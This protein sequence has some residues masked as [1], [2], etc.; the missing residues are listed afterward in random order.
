MYRPPSFENRRRRFLALPTA[1]LAALLLDACGGGKAPSIKIEAPEPPPQTRLVMEVSASPKLNLN[2]DGTAAPLVVRIY[3]L[4]G[5]GQFLGS[6]FFPLFEN[7]SSTLGPDLIAREEIRVVPGETR[8]IEKTL[9][10]ATTTLGVLGAYRSTDQ[11]RWRATVP[12]VPQT[13]N[14]LRLDL[15]PRE[16]AL[17]PEP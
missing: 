6:G 7:D 1:L 5:D 8:T 4:S 15:G 3:E 2:T 14:R 17:T 16:L 11:R 9:N 13:V 12:V 10:P